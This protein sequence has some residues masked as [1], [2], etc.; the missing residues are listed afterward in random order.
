MGGRRLTPD[1]IE[2]A[3]KVFAKTGNEA[4]AAEAIGVNRST[5]HAVFARLKIE[6]N[7]TLH[8]RACERGLRAARERLAKVAEVAEKVIATDTKL[9]PRDLAALLNAVAKNTD[10]LAGVAERE[11][12]RKQSRL[13]RQKTR[14][15]IELLQRKISGEHVDRVQVGTDDALDQRITELLAAAGRPTPPDEGSA[16]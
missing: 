8:A 6:R 10:T 3:S 7:R 15:E 9:A 16:G 11:E 14:A 12:R 5:M 4:A 2:K 1:E 13:T